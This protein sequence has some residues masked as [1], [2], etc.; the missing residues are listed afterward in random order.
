MELIRN[1]KQMQ[2]R[3]LE[4]EK[5]G[6]RIGFV[7]TMGALHE[8]HLSLVDV[9]KNYSD[10]VV[11]SIYLNPAQFGP[12]ED[13]ANYPKS[14]ER[15][16]ELA[17][18]K[19]VDIIF[20]PDNAEMYP[21]G[22]QTSVVTTKL[23]KRLCGA[24]RPA[25]FQGVTTVVLKLFNIVRPNIAV[26]GEKDYQQLKVIEQMTKDL[27]LAV[28]IVPAPIVREEDGLAMSSRNENL[29]PEERRAARSINEA[30]NWAKTAVK[31]GETNPA[32]LISEIRGRIEGTKTGKIDYIAICD[33][34]TLEE[35]EEVKPPFLLAVAAY[36]GKTRLI[37]NCILTT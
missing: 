13:L 6:K 5:L 35:L 9:A 16:I 1:P 29:S 34:E 27:N 19:G 37:D 8:G 14:F 20:C 36:F 26:F 24:S 7:P 32:A 23:T 17:K 11:M 2:G 3:S 22:F 18:S 10:I 25:H 28:K 33:P 30:L 4:L 15:D 31:N 12:N 21:D